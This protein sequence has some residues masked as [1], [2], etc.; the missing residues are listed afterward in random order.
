MTTL[1]SPLHHWTHSSIAPH[2][3]S[4]GKRNSCDA[5]SFK[6]AAVD[7]ATDRLDSEVMVVSLKSPSDEG[8]LLVCC[9]RFI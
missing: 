4:C 7:S 2:L 3:P 8:F 6:L 5:G 1:A 9:F